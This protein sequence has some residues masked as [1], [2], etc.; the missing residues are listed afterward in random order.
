MSA[1]KA[2]GKR[3]GECLHCGAAFLPFRKWQ[4]FCSPK[5]RKNDWLEKNS[6]PSALAAF[7][8][9][10]AEIKR[11]LSEIEANLGIKKGG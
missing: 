4:K 8:K 10:W 2:A 5:C 3:N 7:K 11:R 6:Y 1:K 9:E